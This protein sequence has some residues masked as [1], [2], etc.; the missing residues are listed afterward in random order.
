M[1]WTS[2]RREF[3]ASIVVFLV[4]LP[5]S[6][7][8]ALASD[9]PLISGL[10]AAAIGGIVGGT[11]GG[12]PLLVSGP[13]A[14]LAVIVMDLSERFGFRTLT[15]I[16][17]LAGVL[18]ILLGLGKVARYA[19]AVAPA[20]LHGMLAGIGILIAAA[21]I[22]VV[23]GHAPASSLWKN[24]LAVPNSLTH[25]NPAAL[26]LGLCT[27]LL[28]LAWPRLP[29]GRFKL[30]P[31]LVAVG[32]STLLAALLEA[33]VPHVQLPSHLVWH[34][35]QLGSDISWTSLAAAVVGMALIASTESLL[36][37]VAVDKLHSGPR[38]DLDREL[39]GQGWAN[40]LSGLAGGLPITGVILRST[41]NIEAGAKTRYP[42]ILCGVWVIVAV[43]CA[44][45]VLNAVPLAALGGLLC[46]VGVRLVSIAEAKELHRHGES[47]VYGAT[48]VGI[49]SI[50]LLA[51]I[52]I[53]LCVAVLKLVWQLGRARI[54]VQHHDAQR[55]TVSVQGAVTFMFV[56]DLLAALQALPPG[57]Q[58]DIQVH[59]LMVDHAAREALNSWRSG[60]Q[61]QGQGG[62]ATI[63]MELRGRP[64]VNDHHKAA[65]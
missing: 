40:L 8:I 10:I 54:D 49:V 25:A 59:A 61:A 65:A 5:L 27:I 60:Y 41:V 4:S 45:G 56:P 43:S 53:G 55:T 31:A 2:I 37:A 11:L 52:G 26:G 35:P 36:S 33:K 9:A 57:K 58:I 28:L 13:A 15:L 16:T 17:L 46:V 34:A 39:T 47:L 20:V 6:L 24:I 32:G 3:A 63:H 48:V 62:T 44:A 38:A 19:T 29:L 21:Q 12:A 50:N 18:Q 64:E 30:P 51:G 42:A 22:H 1:S 23:F 14:G 7:G